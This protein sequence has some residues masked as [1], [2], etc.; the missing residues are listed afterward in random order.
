[1]G[2][3]PRLAVPRDRGGKVT[4]GEEFL[5]MTALDFCNADFRQRAVCH[6]VGSIVIA[7]L[8]NDDR[9][10]IREV[11]R[12]MH[13]AIAP[14]GK[15]SDA[16][17]GIGGERAVAGIDEIHKIVRDVS[18]VIAGRGRSPINE[19]SSAFWPFTNTAIISPIWRVRII[20]SSAD[21]TS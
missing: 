16:S 8:C 2:L 4:A 21:C 14:H 6:R 10:G 11:E 13:G 17:T 7:G 20:E 9:E 18:F 12:E 15:A 19:P 5:I 1:M 3:R